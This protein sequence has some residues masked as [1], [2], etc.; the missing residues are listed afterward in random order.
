M[1]FGG[2]RRSWSIGAADF[3]RRGSTFMGAM[4]RAPTDTDHRHGHVPAFRPAPCALRLSF[5][6]RHGPP[7][8]T[9]PCLPPCALSLVPLFYFKGISPRFLSSSVRIE[10][11]LTDFPS[12]S[13]LSEKVRSSF[14]SLNQ[15][16]PKLS[17]FTL[18]VSWL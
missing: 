11:M 8:R 16:S 3:S 13:S 4:N 14:R 17:V 7:T 2:F 5:H 1:C 10:S 6:S 15:K 12:F 9:R 18:K